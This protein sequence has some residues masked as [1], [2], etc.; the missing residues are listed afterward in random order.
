[1]TVSGARAM[2]DSVPRGEGE[3]RDAARR[4]KKWLIVAALALVG[5][6]PGLY[7]GWQHGAAAVESREVVWSPTLAVVLAALYLAATLGGGL[8]LGRFTDELER[9]RNYKAVSVAGLALMTVYPTWF[10]LWKGGFVPE[11]VHWML[12]LLFWLSL[13]LATLWYRVR[14]G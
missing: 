10:L 2:R 8:L 5:F 6:V 9:Q 11:P 14:Q 13:A 1:M 4:R 12:F 7:V 3:R